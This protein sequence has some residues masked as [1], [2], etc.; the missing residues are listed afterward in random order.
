MSSGRASTDTVSM[1]CISVPPIRLTAGAV[2]SSMT[3]TSA[4][5]LRLTSVRKK[6]TWITSSVTGSRWTSLTKQMSSESE[7]SML[8]ETGMLRPILGRSRRSSA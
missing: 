2:P 7:P 4:L 5:T 8:I 3:G 6:S 1:F